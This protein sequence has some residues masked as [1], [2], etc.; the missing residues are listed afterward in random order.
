VITW[1]HDSSSET[2]PGLRLSILTTHN[3]RSVSGQERSEGA[4]RS[5][6]GAT[7]E[8]GDAD[9]HRMNIGGRPVTGGHS[10]RRFATSWSIAI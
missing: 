10:G 8:R 3:G 7:L 1:H 4:L 6:N 9:E 2:N 5:R